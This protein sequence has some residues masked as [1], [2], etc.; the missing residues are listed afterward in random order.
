MKR[1]LP[2][3]FHIPKNAGTYT[4]NISFRFIESNIFQGKKLYNLQVKKGDYILYR[5]ACSIENPDS[6]IYTKG[7]RAIIFVDY[8]DLDI[9]DLTLY[10]VEVCARSFNSYDTDIYKKLT[11]DTKPYEFLFLR[12]PYDRTVS[13]FSY[14]QSPQSSHEPS[15]GSLGN[16]TFIEYL[17]SPELQG[18]WLIHGLLNIPD[19]KKI[20][21]DNFEKTCVLLDEMLV[22]DISQVDFA[23]AK[24][25]KECYSVD[26]IE[27]QNKKI[28]YNK[29]ENKISQPFK[30]L[31]NETKSAFL[32]QTQWDKRIYDRYVNIT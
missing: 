2:V 31:D 11:K 24:V 17:N 14:V 22:S 20:I 13:L 29:T 4:Y 30:D 9:N 25:F 16:S 26:F 23:I 6:D 8:E 27:V 28:Y 15:H 3:F 12:E 7:H 1:K 18:S 32:N 19:E 5:L 10:F 21:Q